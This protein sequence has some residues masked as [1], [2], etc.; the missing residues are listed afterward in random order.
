ML[1][2]NPQQERSPMVFATNLGFPRVGSDRELKKAL[3]SYWKVKS[4]L[5]DLLAAASGLRLRHWKLQKEAGI[6]HIPSNDFSFYDHVLDTTCLLGAVP[7]RFGHKGGD[8]PLDTYFAMA[9]GADKA[10]AMD[11]TKW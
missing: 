10:P 2:S 5:A 8:V 1:F 4:K 7:R 3:E 11:M 6:D 9:R